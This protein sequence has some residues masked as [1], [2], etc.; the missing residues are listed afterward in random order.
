MWTIICDRIA[1]TELPDCIF[2]WLLRV[3]VLWQELLELLGLID[4]DRKP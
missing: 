2:V 3:V 4:D 1:G